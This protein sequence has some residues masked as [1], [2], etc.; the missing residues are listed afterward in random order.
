MSGRTA[1]VVASLAFVLS[2]ATTPAAHGQNRDYLTEGNTLLEQG[3]P[4]LAEAVFREAIVAEPDRSDVF[5]AQ[6]ALSL[7]HRG[8][9][10]AADLVL[11]SLMASAP[12]DPAAVWYYGLSS[13]F[14]GEFIAA[15]ERFAAAIPV[16]EAA[17][18][19]DQVYSAHYFVGESYYELLR[20]DGLSYAQV[21]AML[22]AYD[23]YL[24]HAPPDASTPAYRERAQWLRD[25]RPPENVVRWIHR[26]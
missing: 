15:V 10:Q 18:R 8:E 5:E 24:A 13:F 12:N 16:L 7:I 25:H 4:E 26:Y 23:F 19:H 6:L 1:L 22:A 11:E 14:A 21:D 3:Q 17:G 2:L 20:T 9:F